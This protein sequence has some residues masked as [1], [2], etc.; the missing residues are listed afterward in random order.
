MGLQQPVTQVALNGVDIGQ[1]WTF[2]EAS[3]V[4]RVSGL[5]DLT[6]KGAWSQ[7]W[8]LSWK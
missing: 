7:E 1:V 8:T 2:D 5:N 6:K 4:L 3:R